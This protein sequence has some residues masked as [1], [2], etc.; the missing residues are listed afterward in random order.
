[1]RKERK[2]KPTVCRNIHVWKFYGISLCVAVM[3]LCDV[4]K[5]Y[6]RN[7]EKK[8]LEKK[9]VKKVSNGKR[10]ERNEFAS[11]VEFCTIH[12]VHTRYVLT[13]PAKISHVQMCLCGAHC[14]STTSSPTRRNINTQYN[15][16]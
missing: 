13:K 12:T 8:L 11:A 14:L 16:I 4:F 6:T 2:K 1:M 9:V 10:S 3:C 5:N 7:N 15:G